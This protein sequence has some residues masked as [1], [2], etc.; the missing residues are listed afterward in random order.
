LFC[1]LA[2]LCSI[3]NFFAVSFSSNNNNNKKGEITRQQPKKNTTNKAAKPFLG[4]KV[5][6]NRLFCLLTWEKPWQLTYEHW[7]FNVCLF[8]ATICIRKMFS[9]C[10]RK[11]KLDE[12]CRNQSIS[13]WKDFCIR[14]L[15]S[16]NISVRKGILC[17]CIIKYECVGF[18]REFPS[19]LI[20]I[21]CDKR[22]RF[23]FPLS[24]RLECSM[25]FRF[26]FLAREWKM[27][28]R[29]FCVSLTSLLF[30]RGR[31]MKEIGKTAAHNSFLPFFYFAYSNS[32]WLSVRRKSTFP[33]ITCEVKCT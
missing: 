33:F 8:S 10:Y 19:R 21:V 15:V 20:I 26:V 28:R 27:F 4:R 18:A 24:F 31:L 32:V 1:L 11:F 3:H 14:N 5:K 13:P 22:S 7:N 23:H 9:I 17:W 29:C 16:S 30:I 12:D 6:F 25:Y 2:T